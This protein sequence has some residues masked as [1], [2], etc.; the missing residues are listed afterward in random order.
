MRED[1]RIFG[2]EGWQGKVYNR[3]MEEAS[4][5]SKELS[6]SSHASGVNEYVVPFSILGYLQNGRIER[7]ACLNHSLLQTGKMSWKLLKWW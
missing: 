7:T 1:G 2:G 6:H 4:E 5:N 3:G